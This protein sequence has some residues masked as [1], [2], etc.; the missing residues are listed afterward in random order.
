[1]FDVINSECVKKGDKRLEPEVFQDDMCNIMM[2]KKI[3]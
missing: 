2:H 1:M 3:D